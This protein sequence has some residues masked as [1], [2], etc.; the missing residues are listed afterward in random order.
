M[1]IN[2]KNRTFSKI[3]EWKISLELR[4]EEVNEEPFGSSICWEKI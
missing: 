3:C 2:Q 4:K 1:S